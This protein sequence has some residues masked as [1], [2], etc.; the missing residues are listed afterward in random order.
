[1]SHKKKD[2][3]DIHSA[4]LGDGLSFSDLWAV[5]PKKLRK[6]R[7]KVVV[8]LAVVG[9]LTPEVAITTAE[10]RK[11][12]QL[13]L[14][15]EVPRNVTDVLRKAAPHVEA[16]VDENESLRWWLTKPGLEM[17]KGLTGVSITVATRSDSIG[18]SLD[19]LHPIIQD[20]AKQLFYNEHYAE[21]VGAA[22][23]CLNMLVRRRTDRP[24]DTGVGMMQQVFAVDRNGSIRLALD[25]PPLRQEWQRDRQDGFRFLMAGAQQHIANVHKHGH[26]SIAHMT[27]ALEILC[28]LS[29]L[30]RQVEG[31]LRIES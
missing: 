4:H 8:S 28:M 30:T 14:R 20:A 29:F 6:D 22:M 3:Q 10:L 13:H 19:D 18:K 27:E 5:V 26:L 31:A 12:L 9:A 1:M 15:A 21:A 16:T 25:P 11:R 2:H 17:L 24:A 23:K 7:A